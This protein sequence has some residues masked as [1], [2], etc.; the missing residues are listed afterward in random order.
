MQGRI[1][2]TI[3]SMALTAHLCQAQK[4]VPAQ[5]GPRYNQVPL[6]FEENRGQTDPQ[7][8]FLS[9]AKGYTAFLTA[10][11]VVLTV[12]PKEVVKAEGK[13]ASSSSPRR[14]ASSSAVE[15]RLVG[16]AN[17]MAVGENPQPGHVNYFIG[18]DPKQWR[19]NVPTYSRVRYKSIY[20]GIDLIYYG[21]HRQ[22]EYDFVIG[23]H[24]D[25]DSI[26][27]QIRGAQQ[28]QLSSEGNLIVKM[29][30]G[31]LHFQSPSVYQE[32]GGLRIPL[33]GEYVMKS[34][35]R[36][37]F[38][39]PSFDPNKPLVID[40]VLLYSTYL[41]GS[42]DD[43]PTGIAVDS[44]GSVYVSGYTDSTDFP[45]ASLG[46][47]P[48]GS[49]HV[50]VAKFDS[51]GSNLVYADYIGGN[52]QDYG[53]AL[54]LDSANE[55]Y[56]TGS[57]ASSD[58]PVVN[59][60]Q[61]IYPG[62]FNG[63]LTKIS[64]D[65]ASLLYST[66]LGGNGSDI[67]ARVAIDNLSDAFVAG[68]T[69]STNFPIVNA[70]Q[71]TA[72]PNQGGV[73]GN[74]GFLTKFSPDGSS[75]IF[76]TY[77]GGSSNVS[78]QCGTTQCWPQPVSSV[79]GLAL[80]AAG[81]AYVAGTTN[82]Y[83]FPT[84]T[85]AYLTTDSTTQNSSVGFVSKISPSGSLGYSTYF[86]EEFG[87]TDLTGVAVDGSGS[88]YVTGLTYSDGTFPI[89]STSICDPGVSATACSYAFVTKFDATA[90]A[91]T[92]STFLGPNNYAAPAAIVLDQNDDAFILATTSSNTFSTVNG[93]APYAGGN[94][95]LLVEIDPAAGSQLFATY[96]GGSA[97]ETATAMAI[98][99]EGNLYLTGTT[100]ST[101][102]PT[103]QPA[104]QSSLGGNTDGFV[105]K[106]GTISPPL[107]SLTP[108]LLS[109]GS[110]P[111]G[112]TS[113]P[114]QVVLRNMGGSAL[115]IASISVAGDF[116]ES[117]NCGTSVAASGSCT[118][119]VTFTPTAAGQRTGSI[120]ITD[121]AAGSPHVVSLSG[122]GSAAVVALSPTSLVFSAVA[123]GSSSAS[124]TVTLSN[125]GNSSL[126]ISSVQ[127][128]GDFAQTN[129]CPATI[130]AASS[131]TISVTF[132]PT[133]SGNR[134]GALTISDSAAGS[135]HSVSL[136]GS[137]SDFTLVG[138]PSST[139]K[140]GGSVAF[141]LTVTPTGGAFSNQ[142]QLSCSGAPSASTCTLS[143][144]S[145]TPGSNPASV[146]LTVATTGSTA[147]ALPILPKE[148]PPVN[149][150]WIPLQGLGLFGV[151]LMGSSRRR[152][153]KALVPVLLAL[154]VSGLLFMSACAGGTG[155][156]K[157]NGK[158]TPAGTYTITVTG[159]SGGLHHSVPLTLTVQ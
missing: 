63:F 158:G 70:Y 18:S 121:D 91:L 67:P 147:D 17:A 66:Y 92:Y 48:P 60:Y 43:Q 153:Q 96:L 51:S 90:S 122:T 106:I 104:F 139:V 138:S 123:V 41:G 87:F 34:P 14:G 31:E 127:V 45:L 65:G 64:S 33:R 39:I 6:A 20:P 36:I 93:L 114:Q 42:G 146:S 55:V 83:D 150:F 137:G 50:F 74:Y 9:R 52:S 2:G 108:S 37:G 21:N 120:T 89:T 25:P 1:V 26:Q 61:G 154:V 54:A 5:P 30:D 8:K 115:T 73:Y 132:A 97:D 103:T 124:Q 72:S 68:S 118:L 128:T 13:P 19:T 40:P 111:V 10:R 7:V 110:E 75:L 79:T 82:T 24:S 80:D 131:C 129:N 107:V 49:D 100:D 86:Y 136:S 113:S 15:F 59:A 85:G 58:F 143:P 71:S 27:F 125:Q 141:T 130:V 78:F 56:V 126:S 156:V 77:L 155:I 149:A 135:P 151:V 84:T 148:K 142:I 98:D 69:S 99:T 12:R 11:G 81:N 112:S 62:S 32:S 76:S 95:V 23:P 29:S 3:L 117:D 94:D 53:Y 109:F 44:Q 28:V 134:N 119:S 4:S 88:A 22:L 105:M 157:Q 102:L 38:H 47:L 57:T 152:R 101:D 46:S 116:A 144:T 16:T 145:V 159:T 133:A 35:T 140:A